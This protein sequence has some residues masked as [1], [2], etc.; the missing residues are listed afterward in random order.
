VLAETGLDPGL[1][2]LELT[3][4]FLMQDSQA[5][6]TIVALKDLGVRIAL[7]D[8]GTGYSSLSYLKRFPVDTL[9]IDRSFISNITSDPGDACIAR[10]VI[11]MGA[12]LHMR[13]VAEGVETQG[14]LALLLA[15]NCPE[16][17][18]YYFSRAVRPAEFAELLRHPLTPD[19]QHRGVTV[20]AKVTH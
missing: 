7:D 15:M 10:A 9:K 18:G 2:E 11:G 6:E 12:G 3:E 4:T 5:G 14:Q 20:A 13:V 17:Q 8:F 16:G 19:V 1:L